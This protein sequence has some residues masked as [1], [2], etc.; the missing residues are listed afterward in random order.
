MD[1]NNQ[2]IHIAKLLFAQIAF[3]LT[4][5]KA[6]G[7]FILKIFDSFMEHTVDL[8]YLLSSFYDK[9]YIIKPNTSRYANSE[10]YVIC[11]GFLYSSHVAFY[12]YLYRAF[13]KMVCAHVPPPGFAPKELHVHRFLNIPVAYYFVKKIEEYNAIFGQQQIDNI[14]FTILLIDNKHKQDRIESLIKTNVQKC[15]HWCNKN[16]VSFH[17]MT[18]EKNNVFMMAK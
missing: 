15:T 6:G 18:M 17:M 3:A 8:L 9:V 7:A 13:E 5:Q 16:N 1:F 12:P 2:E 10:K 11:K 14:H 4:M